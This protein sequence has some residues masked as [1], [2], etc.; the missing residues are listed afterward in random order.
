MKL[1]YLVFYNTPNAPKFIYHNLHESSWFMLIPMIIL[2]FAS[3]FIGYLTRDIYLG[4]PSIL[5]GI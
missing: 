4:S 3:I 5:E 1:L 2:S